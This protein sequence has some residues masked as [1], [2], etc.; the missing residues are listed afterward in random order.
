MLY[1]TTRTWNNNWAFDKCLLANNTV[2]Y[3]H[4]DHGPNFILIKIL[5][6]NPRTMEG[7]YAILP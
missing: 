1:K 2:L 3:V 7:R 6:M 4:L 5:D